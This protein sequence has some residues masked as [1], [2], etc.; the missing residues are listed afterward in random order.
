MLLD[1]LA[2]RRCEIDVINGGVVTR[3]ELAGVPTPVNEALSRAVRARE[4]GE[5][6]RQ[7]RGISTV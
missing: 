5:L 6:R 1:V 3:G 4:T 2:H 7:R